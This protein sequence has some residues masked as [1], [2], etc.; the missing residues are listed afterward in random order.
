MN[1]ILLTAAVLLLSACGFHLKGTQGISK[2]LPYQSWQVSGGNMQTALENALQRADGK[3]VQGGGAQAQLVVTG[4]EERRDVYTVTRAAVINEYL[5]TLRVQAQAVRLGEAIGEPID[6]VI[7]RTMD[8]ADSE[9]LGKAE[10]GQTV[11][12]EMRADAA[13]QIV[14]RLT[15]IQGK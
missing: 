1:K 7:E 8:Y 2:P 3:V 12:S 5:L 9:V 14:R 10:E 15:F 13:E 6:V 11:W 4:V